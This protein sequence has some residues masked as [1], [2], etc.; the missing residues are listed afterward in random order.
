[1]MQT[2][3][4]RQLS[5]NSGVQRQKQAAKWSSTPKMAQKLAFNS[6][7]DLYTCNIQAQPKHTSSGPRKWIYAS[8][9]YFYK[10]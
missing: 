5:A 10:P 8:I 6:K 3:V 2:G 7:I 9:T 4:Q 1:M